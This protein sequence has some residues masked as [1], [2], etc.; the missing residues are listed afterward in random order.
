[1]KKTSKSSI[2]T[3]NAH[4]LNKN[5]AMKYINLQECDAAIKELESE[6]VKIGVSP[7]DWKNNRVD[8]YLEGGGKS[9]IIDE[10]ARLAAIY[11]AET[12]S[13]QKQFPDADMYRVG[14]THG[15]AIGGDYDR[16]KAEGDID[17]YTKDVQGANPGLVIVRL[18][19]GQMGVQGNPVAILSYLRLDDPDVNEIT[20]VP[21]S[22]GKTAAQKK[23]GKSSP[24]AQKK[25]KSSS[26]EPRPSARREDA[27]SRY[28]K[29]TKELAARE[30]GDAMGLDEKA[31]RRRI[32]SLYRKIARAI[33]SGA[34]ASTEASIVNEPLVPME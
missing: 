16:L 15:I 28:D 8:G 6:L 25:E 30:A 18:K 27:Q 22:G 11:T 33:R 20:P 5:H 31:N 26:E 4:M 23:E 19:D 1:M 14:G 7:R 13:Q 12:L 34:V 17:F 24:A 21:V 2:F 9:A 10:Y 29:Y 32:A 3:L